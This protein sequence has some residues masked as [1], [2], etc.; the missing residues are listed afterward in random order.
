MKSN[1]LKTI[2][3]VISMVTTIIGIQQS[4]QAASTLN[5]FKI[6]PLR[7]CADAGETIKTLRFN[8]YQRVRYHGRV[9]KLGM[10]PGPNK[11]TPR[12][13]YTFTQII[14]NKSKVYSLALV[15][16]GQGAYKNRFNEEKR[17][18]EKATGFKMM[19]KKNARQHYCRYRDRKT[20]TA[21]NIN[22][23]LHE[24][25]RIGINTFSRCK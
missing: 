8:G 25:N 23:S 24:K 17:R 10:L 21:F 6:G 1:K 2:S 7:L 20:N 19:C 9:P 14:W 12:Y 22:A 13:Q 15:I 16:T 4:A 11:R 18:F 5:G 3:L